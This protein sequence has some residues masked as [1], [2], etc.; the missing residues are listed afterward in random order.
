MDA[1]QWAKELARR[2]Q[3]QVHWQNYPRTK[4]ELL[5]EFTSFK[6]SWPGDSLVVLDPWDMLGYGETDNSEKALEAPFRLIGERPMEWFV[7]DILR[8]HADDITADISIDEEGT[9]GTICRKSY[10][11]KTCRYI[12]GKP[13][14]HGDN[15]IVIACNPSK[16]SLTEPDDTMDN[17]VETVGLLGADGY[18]VLN[19][20]P[21]R[22]GDPDQLP[23]EADERV[24]DENVRAFR[25][26]LAM[27]F[28]KNAN[29]W[30]AWGGLIRKRPYLAESLGRIVAAFKESGHQGEW[31]QMGEGTKDGHPRHPNPR[32]KRPEYLPW[33][34][35]PNEFDVEAYLA[36]LSR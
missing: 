33:N 10:D 29:V 9:D 32:I 7:E 8:R 16:A 20:Y 11:G 18:V 13:S 4:R 30:A 21:A 17:I 6:L 15:I 12:L 26:V 35:Q 24:L 2:Q 25:D 19:L 36:G 14:E 5:E 3:E 31:F 23:D 34:M 27:P 1:R 28:M 22:S